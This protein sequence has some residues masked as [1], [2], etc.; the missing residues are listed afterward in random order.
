MKRSSSGADKSRSRGRSRS[1]DRDR[2]RDRSRTT[3]GSRN[4]GRTSDQ[5]RSGSRKR[6]AS[7]RSRRSRSPDDPSESSRSSSLGSSDTSHSDAESAS[8]DNDAGDDS[9][10]SNF[11]LLKAALSSA[12]KQTAADVLPGDIRKQFFPQRRSE[13]ADVTLYTRLFG[14]GRAW[15]EL[16]CFPPQVTM[17]DLGGNVS[18][19][20][21][22]LAMLGA[23]YL[24][25]SAFRMAVLQ[26]GMY[27]LLVWLHTTHPEVIASPF[28][29]KFRDIT[30][31]AAATYSEQVEY[32]RKHTAAVHA[33][34]IELW[35]LQPPQLAPSTPLNSIMDERTRKQV[36][37]FRRVDKPR[38]SGPPSTKTQQGR[39]ASKIFPHGGGQYRSNNG[40]GHSRQ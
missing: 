18:G 8:S 7:K 5:G 32:L 4:Q 33:S 29:A 9:A 24:Q 28:A 17:S 19:E 12:D 1:R 3:S 15:S 14:N 25:H 30:N 27:N 10:A 37:R 26:T 35:S 39:G 13:A 38:P 23:R 40:H 36:A 2:D 11:R 34:R 22:T 16:E 20:A 31:W 21:K 6:S